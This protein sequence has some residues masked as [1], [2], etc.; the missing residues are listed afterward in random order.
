[1]GNKNLVCQPSAPRNKEGTKK[2]PSMEQITILGHRT[3]E[4]D[5]ENK[6]K[7]S[8]T[9]HDYKEETKN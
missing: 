2:I 7:V 5:M 8:R 9:N 4:Y 1:M 3:N 6:K